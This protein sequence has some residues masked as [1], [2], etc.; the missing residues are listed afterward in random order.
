MMDKNMTKMINNL[1]N[2][3]DK[4]FENNIFNT[5]FVIIVTV[6]AAH[7]A[8]RLPKKILYLFN[9]NIFKIIFI[10]F[11]AYSATKNMKIAI[12]SSIAL[13]IIIQSLNFIETRNKIIKKIKESTQ[14]VS[15]NRIKVINKMIENPIVEKRQK[16]ALVDNV[17]KSIASDKHK[18]NTAISFINSLPAPSPVTQFKIIKKLYSDDTNIRKENIINM[19]KRLLL[20]KKICKKNIGKITKLMLNS[21][22]Q[23]SDKKNIIIDIIKKINPKIKILIMK[24]IKDSNISNHHKN[25]II[26]NIKNINSKINKKTDN[27]IKQDIDQDIKY[28]YDINQYDINENTNIRDDINEDSK[29]SYDINENTICQDDINGF[30]NKNYAEC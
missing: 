14:I 8:P 6:F 16:I 11:I 3:I 2:Y 7:F 21:N 13:V 10:S 25:K 18:F 29:Y 28:Q 1:K 19:S 22:I 4:L 20:N 30:E 27:Y 23:S 5:M 15:D 12:V 17:M 26:K 24:K 9:N